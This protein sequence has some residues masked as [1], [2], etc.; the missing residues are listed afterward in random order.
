MVFMMYFMKN[1]LAG[2]SKN[3]RVTN[4]KTR[5]L[6]PNRVLEFNYGIKL[7]AQLIAVSKWCGFLKSVN[8]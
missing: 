2:F 4:F 8:K 6:G 5:V 7:K 1:H 3:A